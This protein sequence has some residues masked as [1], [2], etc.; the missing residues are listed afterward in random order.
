MTRHAIPPQPAAQAPAKVPGEVLEAV[1]QSL[2]GLR[3]GV[4]QLTV[5]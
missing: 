1:A 2:V 4:I 5:H 3:F